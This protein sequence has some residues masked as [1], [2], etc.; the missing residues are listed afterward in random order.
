VA[1]DLTRIIKAL[2]RQLDPPPAAPIVVVDRT[3][4]RMLWFVIGAAAAGVVFLAM[5]YLRR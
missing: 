2:A 3:P 1:E 4:K 5:A